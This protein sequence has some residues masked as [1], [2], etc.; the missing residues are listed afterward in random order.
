[1]ETQNTFDRSRA[2]EVQKSCPNLP[3][4]MEHSGQETSTFI[5]SYTVGYTL[6]LSAYTCPRGLKYN[7]DFCFYFFL[8]VSRSLIRL[9]VYPAKKNKKHSDIGEHSMS[10]DTRSSSSTN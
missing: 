7:L 8:S 10:R 3:Q 9:K 4:T 2:V 6:F 5:L 1:M